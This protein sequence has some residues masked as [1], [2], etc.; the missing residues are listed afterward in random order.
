M[1]G[2]IEKIE[3]KNEEDDDD[4]ELINAKNI[5]SFKIKKFKKRKINKSKNIKRIFKNEYF[6][7]PTLFCIIIIILLLYIIVKFCISNI[8][9]L[10]D[11]Q[12]NKNDNANENKFFINN[13]YNK[14]NS[15]F[16]DLEESYEKGLNFINKNVEGILIEANIK[17]ISDNPQI[18][19]IIPVYNSRDIILRSV[20]SIQN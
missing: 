19:V 4:E 18:S 3:D 7:Y 13:I 14:E 1:D 6:N 10:E 17:N 11:K 8:N 15:D 2:K 20:R 16:D 12:G 9:N 5:L